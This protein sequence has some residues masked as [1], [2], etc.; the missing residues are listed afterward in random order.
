[1]LSR[2]VLGLGL[3]RVR[4]EVEL[5]GGVRVVAGAGVGVRSIVRDNLLAGPAR[6]ESF[7]VNPAGVAETKREVLV[8]WGVDTRWLSSRLAFNDP[9]GR[10]V[11]V[12]G[13]SRLEVGVLVVKRNFGEFSG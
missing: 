7:R 11:R 4:T 2:G 12:G 8:D 5:V 3:F 9:R 10:R 6:D 1:L 13:G